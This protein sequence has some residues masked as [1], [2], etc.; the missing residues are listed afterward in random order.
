MHSVIPEPHAGYAEKI[1][2][3]VAADQASLRDQITK[4]TELS[5]SY[6]TRLV[7]DPSIICV[8][9]ER[10]S[11]KT[12]VLATAAAQLA[13]DGHFVIPPIRP[14]YFVAPSSLIPT[15]VAHLRTT[16]HTDWLDRRGDIAHDA[17]MKLST[18]LE[19]TLR[20]ASLVFYDGKGS[21]LLRADEQA[22]DRSLA[23]TADS[24][25][26]DEWRRLTAQIR[27]MAAA[28]GKAHPLI[29]I[30]VDDP[31]LAP[32]TLRQ[33]LL[34]LRLMTSVDGVVGITCLD[35][36]EARSV[37]TDAYT[38]SY[39]RPPS[40]LLTTRVVDAQIAKAFP[41]DRRVNIFGLDR[42]QKLSFKALDLPLP[43]I[44][45]LCRS[46]KIEG[47]Y[48]LDTLA[49]VFRLPGTNRP[50]LYANALPSNPRDLR[51]LAYRLSNIPPNSPSRAAEA[52]M[53]LCRSTMATG[54]KQSGASEPGLWSSGLPFE[55]L[56]ELTDGKPSCKL[57][58]DDIAVMSSGN[59][60]RAMPGS[61][62]EDS[63][64]RVVVGY[65]SA[66]ETQLRQRGTKSEA[67]QRLDPALSYALVLVREFSDYYGLI[68]ASISGSVPIRGGETPS[69]YFGV[70]LDRV[71]TDNCFL[72]APPWEAYY[73]YFV[74]D[75]AMHTL[76]PAATREHELP[77]RRFVIEG[78][79]ID[80]CRSVVS[81]QRDRLSP[82]DPAR[83]SRLIREQGE[84]GLGELL[85]REL[86][87]L[88]KDFEACLALEE[89]RDRSDDV[90]PGDFKRWVEV[91][92]VNMC[93]ERLLRPSFIDRF[94]QLRADLLTREHR[95][96]IA[97]TEAA[98]A[99]ER[100]IKARLDETWVLPLIELTQRFDDDLG[101]VLL[102][103][104][105][106]ALQAVERGRHRLLGESALTPPDASLQAKEPEQEQ[107]SDYEV[108]LAVLD[109]LEIE[110]Q[111]QSRRVDP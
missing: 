99:L 42:E 109:Q 110:T 46:Y 52:A 11:G 31:D 16:V 88:F 30:P 80:F 55:V 22:A 68:N 61:K 63:A 8:A 20:Q 57:R 53:E 33:I 91:G 17:S 96:Q 101:M 49:S 83:V 95:L 105:H 51:G 93:H 45:E 77:D 12:T 62:D 103:S 78:Y 64:T 108:A 56:D 76:V 18:A 38:G 69:G 72:N 5:D 35:L 87:A 65:A 71:N 15:T 34:D 24:D 58:F 66:V 3:L 19:R 106:A 26:L 1:R 25:F 94:L 4:E 59:I 10:G 27:E 104:H 32:G 28:Q 102:A 97:N 85:D 37:L 111:V 86:T 50:S 44:E 74:L 89:T 79:F 98:S 41:D 23:A 84:E 82:D 75:E 60:Q 13:D 48:G 2:E 90:R 6:V 54:L 9:G 14:E 100:R 81:V 73:D 7:E 29:V 47:E 21:P 92:L 36:D 107:T 39:H 43:S 70:R 40:L 67:V